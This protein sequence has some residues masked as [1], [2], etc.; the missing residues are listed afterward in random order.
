[1]KEMMLKRMVLMMDEVIN[2]IETENEFSLCLSKLMEKL[3][4]G[5]NCTE[6]YSEEEAKKMLGVYIKHK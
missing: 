5:M 2:N 6:S 4:V 1:M 3:E